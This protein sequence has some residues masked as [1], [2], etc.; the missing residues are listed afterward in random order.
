MIEAQ[1]VAEQGRDELILD[2]Q[3]Y[4]LERGIMFMPVTGTRLWAWRERVEGL[5]P[6]FAAS[7]YFHWARLRVKAE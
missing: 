4:V 3:R 5:A 1:S 6:N 7:E 2:I